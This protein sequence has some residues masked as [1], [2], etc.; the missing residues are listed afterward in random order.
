[1]PL[2]ANDKTYLTAT[3]VPAIAAAVA[4]E[5][6]TK[7]LVPATNRPLQTVIS[8]LF[9][10]EQSGA[11]LVAPASKTFRQA[12]LARIEAALIADATRDAAML[13]AI[14]GQRAVINQLLGAIQTGGGDP[15]ITALVTRLDALPGQITA[16]AT[17]AAD[18]VLARVRAAEL[19]QAAALAPEAPAPGAPS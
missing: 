9:S 13:T 6:L 2:D 14:D 4:N 8:D 15:D 1:M 11:S 7:R 12:Q 17:G 19:A 10:G 16:A 3:L 5:I 18:A